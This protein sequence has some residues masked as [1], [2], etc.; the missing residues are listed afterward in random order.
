[1]LGNDSLKKVK[2]L[3]NAT[4]SGAFDKINHELLMAILHYLRFSDNAP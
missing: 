1:M 3:S 4:Y 2:M